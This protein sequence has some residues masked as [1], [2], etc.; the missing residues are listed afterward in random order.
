M[1]IPGLFILILIV[2]HANSQSFGLNFNHDALLVADVDKSAIFYSE[3]LGLKEIVNRTE[4]PGRR[5]LSMGNGTELHLIVGDPTPVYMTKSIHFA[6]SANNFE[7]FVEN[8]KNRKIAYSS[9]EGEGNKI[10]IRADGIGQVYIQ[11]L[12]GYWIE[13]N[14]AEKVK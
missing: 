13:I 3:V 10:T 7:G 14:S 9:W 11:D 8:L 4:K 5:W 12:D 6:L 2:S 1:R